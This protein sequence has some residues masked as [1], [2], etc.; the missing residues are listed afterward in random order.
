[1]D[2]VMCQVCHVF[3]LETMYYVEI[4]TTYYVMAMS[5]VKYVM[6]FF[7]M[8]CTILCISFRNKEW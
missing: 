8:P 1:M 5:C 3:H 2:Y 6:Y 7:Y 4:H